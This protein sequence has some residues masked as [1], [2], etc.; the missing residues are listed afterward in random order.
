MLP[1][2]THNYAEKFW[3]CLVDGA[4]TGCKQR[5]YDYSEACKEAERLAN[6]EGKGVTLVEA[7]EYCRPAMTPVEWL[8]MVEG[9]K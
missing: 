6:K 8:K 3:M 2:K 1:E 7:R 5:H 9:G 4:I